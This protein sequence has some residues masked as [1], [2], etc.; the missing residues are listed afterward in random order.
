[1]IA[2]VS[3]R[4]HYPFSP[5]DTEE[6]SVN[7]SRRSKASLAILLLIAIAIWSTHAIG[8]SRRDSR[9]DPSAQSAPAPQQLS[10]AGQASLR[11]IVQAGNLPEL[12]WP[13]FSDYS[14]ILQKFY[15]SYGYSLAWVSGMQPTTQ[16]RQAITILLN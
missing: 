12:R 7:E 15:D 11:A 4:N 6:N 9:P 16:A 10:D 14:K 5:C 2:S 1:M 3:S 8:S 13:D